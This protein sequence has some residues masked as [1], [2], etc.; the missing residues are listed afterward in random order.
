MYL[1]L[2]ILEILSGNVGAL[3]HLL[4]LPASVVIYHITA[5]MLLVVQLSQLLNVWK[6][7]GEN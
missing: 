2:D 4:H 7:V 3:G 6:Q 1:V 5:V